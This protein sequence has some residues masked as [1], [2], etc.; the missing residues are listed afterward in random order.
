MILSIIYLHILRNIKDNDIIDY[1]FNFNDLRQK[2][3]WDITV[4]GEK[5]FKKEFNKLVE[6]DKNENNVVKYL[7]SKIY[8]IEIGAAE[9]EQE[10]EEEEHIY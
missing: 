7:Y 2:D 3:L 4:F 5:D 9:E 8:N 10:E 1:L 6:L